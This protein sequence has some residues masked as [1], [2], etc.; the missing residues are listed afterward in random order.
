MYGLVRASL[1]LVCLSYLFV[2]FLI[3]LRPSWRDLKVSER[4]SLRETHGQGLVEYALVLV[5]VAAVV[6]TSLMALGPQVG[7]IFSH[8]KTALEFGAT[9]EAVADAAASRT[10]DSNS[11][12]LKVTFRVLSDM[13]V[14]V[15]DSQS[16]QTQQVA[17]SAGVCSVTLTAVGHEA[18]TITITTQDGHTTTIDYPPKP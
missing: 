12:D 5:L 9:E 1:T 3:S 8:V 6:I 17:C 16:G 10:G 7:E 14:Q 13:T 2:S 18:G 4:V 15:T 11:N